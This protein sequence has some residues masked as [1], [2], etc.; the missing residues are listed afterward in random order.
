MASFRGLAGEFESLLRLRKPIIAISFK[1]ESGRGLSESR[2]VVPSSC[3]FWAL[4]L[5]GSFKTSKEQHMNCSIGAVTHGFKDPREIG[6]GCGCRDVDFL[7]DV[8]WVSVDDIWRLPS[9]RGEHEVVSYGPMRSVDFEPDVVLVFCNAEQAMFIASAAPYK[10][11]GKPSC[12]GIPISMAEG[13]VVVGLGCTAS[14]LRAGYKP[15]E[16][17]V[18]IPGRIFPAV[19]E[20]LKKVVEIEEKVAIAVLEDRA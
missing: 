6:P 2:D 4:A 15:E 20:R 11:I 18:F 8:G 5:N 10:I 1:R 19:T 3:S 9:V 13:T 16:L 12:A 17:V 14:R 7:L